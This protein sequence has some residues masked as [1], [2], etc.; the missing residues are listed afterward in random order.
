[1]HSDIVDFTNKVFDLLVDFESYKYELQDLP[2]GEER[3]KLAKLKG[4]AMK[5]LNRLSKE[6]MSVYRKHIVQES[7]EDKFK[8]W[9]KKEI[10]QSLVLS[11]LKELKSPT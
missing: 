8:K 5:A 9:L 1:M 4:D 7:I 2:I 6:S 11:K 3:S 10:N